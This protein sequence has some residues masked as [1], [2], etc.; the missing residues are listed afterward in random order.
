[1]AALLESAVERGLIPKNPARGVAK[2]ADGKRL[3]PFDYAKVASLGTA[4]RELEAAGEN[5]LGIRCVRLLLLTGCRR[6]EIESLKRRTIDFSVGALC[7]A[8]TKSGPQNR[9]IGEPA[10]AFLRSFLPLDGKPDDYV[11]PSNGKVGYFQALPKTWRRVA[12]RAGL[13]GMTIHDL[14]HW[15]ASTAAGMGYTEL[16]IA[17]LL[18]M[19]LQA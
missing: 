13:E 12:E 19:P 5:V 8:D 1:M 16:V 11:F 14:R 18:A 3:P 2:P 10:L 4:M 9:I 17:K 6:N 15:F 7:F